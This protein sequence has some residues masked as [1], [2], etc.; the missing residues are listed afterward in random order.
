M[1]TH[2]LMIF[3]CLSCGAILHREPEQEVPLC[4]GKPMIKAAGETVANGERESLIN[5]PTH[6]LTEAPSPPAGI[7][8]KPR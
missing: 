4:C 8:R 7:E 2:N 1:K 6:P 3:H 5:T